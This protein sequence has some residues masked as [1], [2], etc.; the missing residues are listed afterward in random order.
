VIHY[1][2][3]KSRW[4]EQ[5]FIYIYIYIYIY[6][7]SVLCFSIVPIN[8]LVAIDVYLRLSTTGFSMG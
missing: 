7:I 5:Y 6:M 2:A 1:L 8:F 4:G 3:F